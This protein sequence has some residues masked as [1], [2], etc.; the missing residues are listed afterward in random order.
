[1][2]QY[3]FSYIACIA[4]ALMLMQC[5]TPTQPTEDD[6]RRYLLG[7]QWRTDTTKNSF[8]ANTV[9][10]LC[11]QA[12]GLENTLDFISSATLVAT[13]RDGRKRE[14][15]W[16]VR[17]VLLEPQKT[18]GIQLRVDGEEFLIYRCTQDTLILTNP[19]WDNRADAIC[20]G[21]R[22]LRTPK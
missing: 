19:S 6:V 8:F 22:M 12:A 4:G 2:R 15:S 9:V 18:Q 21:F 10:P 1:M 7:G 13:G 16:E 3:F 20:R 14:Q 5:S 11:S 17:T